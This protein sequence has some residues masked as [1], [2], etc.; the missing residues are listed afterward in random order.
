[1]KGRL[2]LEL[3][4]DDFHGMGRR[5]EVVPF[6]DKI[7]GILKL[8]AS[9][10]I[11]TGRYEHLKRSRVKLP[12]GTMVACHEKHAIN[13]IEALKLT[14]SNP[15]KTPDLDAD[16]PEYSP[17]LDAARHKVYRQ[18]IGHAIYMGIDRYDC[19]RTISLLGKDL[20][21]PTEFSWRRLIRLGR[22]LVG[23]PRLGVWLPRPTN[24]KG[25]VEMLVETDT[26]HAG[27]KNS[28]RSM[29]SRLCV[30]DQCPMFSQVKRQA[31]QSL[32][33]GESEFYGLTDAALE[34]KPLV[35]LYN[36][37]GFT[38]SWT[39]ATDSSTAKS[40]ALRRGI[41]RVRHLDTR[42]LWAQY[43]VA[44]LGLHI[45]KIEGV[46]NRADLGTKV[47]P[48][49]KFESMRQAAGMMPIPPLEAVPTVSVHS[50]SATEA[51]HPLR[52]AITA[53]LRILARRPELVT[54]SG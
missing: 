32:S 13:I 48:S 23:V 35:D 8:K 20:G 47:H 30:V 33:S 24:Q 52:D 1:M 17:P 26:D 25:L 37:L 22:Y 18:C 31:L 46:R 53:L 27:D 19:Q 9:D 29:S 14:N 4:M 51:G 38:V 40:M 36:W 15:C 28:R 42:S 49:E 2:A 3:H 11:V 10:V 5:S 43:A 41:G 7:R 6:L 50:I 16:E 54:E 34:S 45:S 21:K 39:T 44:E 12:H